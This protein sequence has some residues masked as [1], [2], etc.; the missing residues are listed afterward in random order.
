MAEYDV[1]ASEEAP[2]DSGR[3]PN[4]LTEPGYGSKSLSDVLPHSAGRTRN[5]SQWLGQPDRWT[6]C[7]N[8]LSRPARFACPPALKQT[9]S[10]ATLRADAKWIGFR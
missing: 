6:G 8:R 5:F 10:G 2:T 9:H 1:D 4:T 7:G 3:G